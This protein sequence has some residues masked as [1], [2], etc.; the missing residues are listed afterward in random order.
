MLLHGSWLWKNRLEE[1]AVWLDKA[2]AHWESLGAEDEREKQFLK[3]HM[4][5]GRAAISLA[6]MDTWQLLGYL[7]KA[8]GLK[9]YQPIVLGEMNPGEVHMLNT[10]YGFKG[11]LRKIDESY[12]YL[13]ADVP[14]IFGNFSAYLTVI[15]AECQYERDDL[16]AAY[17]TIMQGMERIIELNNPGAIVPC[18]GTL[19]RIKRGAGR[20]AGRF[21]HHRRGQRETGRQEQGILELS[22]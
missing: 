18:F 10:M 1:A 13:T 14:R 7:K 8:A 21:Q 9:I 5:M 2:Q 3:A 15:L 4:L 19:A 12:R 6:K 22:F 17:Q 16:K 20:H 11:R